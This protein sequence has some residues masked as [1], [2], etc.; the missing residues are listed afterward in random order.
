[1]TEET[2]KLFD[3][4]WLSEEYEHGHG[5]W[6]VRRPEGYLIAENM[7]CQVSNRLAR[8]PELYE[9]LMDE[10]I[11]KCN[12]CLHENLHMGR[13]PFTGKYN[14]VEAGCPFKDEVCHTS[15]HLDL[16]KK[17]RDGE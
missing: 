12:E 2:K 4:P 10:A 15:S 1:M 7:A 8:L 5:A 3:A 16:L 11:D 14:F 6:V 17:V 13:I 9:A